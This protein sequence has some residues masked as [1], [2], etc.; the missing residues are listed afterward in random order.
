MGRNIFKPKIPHS[1]SIDPLIFNSEEFQLGYRKYVR[2]KRIKQSLLFGGLGIFAGM[3][4]L[5][6]EK[7]TDDDIPAALIFAS[8]FAFTTF[9]ILDTECNRKKNLGD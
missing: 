5:E 9:I 2:N 8:T 7:S 6:I 1:D 3:A 4:A